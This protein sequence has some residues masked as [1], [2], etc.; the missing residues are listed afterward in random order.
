MKHTSNYRQEKKNEWQPFFG[1]DTTS[2]DHVAELWRVKGLLQVPGGG[3]IIAFPVPQHGQ[4]CTWSN[5]TGNVL[6]STFFPWN[7][8]VH[9]SL[10]GSKYTAKE[11]RSSNTKVKECLSFSPFAKRRISKC[12]FLNVR[13]YSIIFLVKYLELTNYLWTTG[14][15]WRGQS[16]SASM[17]TLPLP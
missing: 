2:S 7:Y 9:L 8:M 16:K 3:P 11:S 4:G 13:F 14:K 17:I 15:Y 1:T 5:F 12:R 10:C 6:P